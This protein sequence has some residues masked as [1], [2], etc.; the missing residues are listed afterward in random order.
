VG[1]AVSVDRLIAIASV[2][3]G[4]LVSW[5]FY[6][7]ALPTRTPTFL[8]YPVRAVLAGGSGE[9][10][11]DI[12]ILYK[13]SPIGQKAIS[14]VRVYFWN[15]GNT[16]IIEAAKDILEPFTITISG[17]SEILDAKI[18]K[19]NRDITSIT[20]EKDKQNAVKVNFRLLESNDGAALQLVYAGPK[21]AKL[22][23]HG[24]TI[25]AP[26]P[27]INTPT[28]FY[29][30]IFNSLSPLQKVVRTH[31][32]FVSFLFFGLVLSVLAAI[33]IPFLRNFIYQRVFKSTKSHDEIEASAVR[34]LIPA[35]V[36]LTTL[37]L[38]LFSMV[39]EVTG[40]I[41]SALIVKDLIL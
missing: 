30:K 27:T 36:V 3:L 1:G 18:L 19:V 26:S 24:A 23:F 9:E 7:A 6:R 14:V 11:S 39:Q 4:V 22:E 16:P 25:G 38:A 13:G 35:V 29:Q 5:Y 34:L 28:D 40:A 31:K 41:P 10:T 21:D 37:G 15:A 2:V 12:T 20:V 17:D 32:D 8:V 33:V